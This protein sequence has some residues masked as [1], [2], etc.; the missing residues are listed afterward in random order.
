MR[1][2]K[3]NKTKT[4][5]KKFPKKTKK[6]IEKRKKSLKRSAAYR[7]Y[8]P[9]GLSEKDKKKQIKS[10]VEGKDRPKVKYPYKPS[11]HKL[12]FIKKYGKRSMQW[13]YDNII[14]KKYAEKIIKKGEAAYYTGGSRPNMGPRQWGVARL[15]S[16]IMNGN[17]RKVDHVEWESGK[18][19]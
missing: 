14:S 7:R 10:I 11:S 15:Y 9:K 6:E 3:K 16:V 2:A 13:I 1:V 18:K 8:V 17:A 5:T 12:R 4:K 19:I